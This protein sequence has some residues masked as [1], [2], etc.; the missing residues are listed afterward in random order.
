[1]RNAQNTGPFRI[2]PSSLHPR[3]LRALISICLMPF[4][5]LFFFLNTLV[6]CYKKVRFLIAGNVLPPSVPLAPS[7]VSGIPWFLC[8]PGSGH[9]PRSWQCPTFPSLMLTLAGTSESYSMSD[10]Y[11]A[12]TPDLAPGCY[13]T[14]SFLGLLVPNSSPFLWPLASGIV[15]ELR[16]NSEAARPRVN[17]L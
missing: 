11:L 1:M 7:L 14:R 8:E 9:L 4:K 2:R 6:S 15:P 13:D 5:S 12:L 10:Q 17:L 16:S 3:F